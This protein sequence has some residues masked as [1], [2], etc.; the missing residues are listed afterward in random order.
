MKSTKVLLVVLTGLLLTIGS[1][2]KNP[3]QPLPEYELFINEFLADNRACCPD[4][5]G[6]YDAWVEIYNAGPDA[7]DLA[8]MYLTDD[9]YA[10]GAAEW[11]QIP[12]S[13]EALTTIETDSFLVFWFDDQPEQGVLHV[14]Q[15][16]AND[17][18]EIYLIGA[19]AATI[20]DSLLYG[21]QTADISFGRVADSSSTW[22]F[23]TGPTPGES[24]ENGL[25]ATTQML[26]FSGPYC[27]WF[28]FTVDT[29]VQTF[30]DIFCSVP[31]ACIM[32][33]NQTY[34]FEM[35]V[36]MTTL[37]IPGRAYRFCPYSADPVTVAVTGAAFTEEI[38]VPM[39]M[40]WSAAET[41]N[42]FSD[43]IPMASITYPGGTWIYVLLYD[44]FGVQ[45]FQPPLI[46]S[47][48]AGTV[49]TDAPEL[50]LLPPDSVTVTISAEPAD[51]HDEVTVKKSN[52]AVIQAIEKLLAAGQEVTPAMMRA[53]IDAE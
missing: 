41:G 29:G 33:F 30:E 48:W 15:T 49:Y 10:D 14:N 21:Q 5:N 52:V 4:E 6:E 9:H 39:Y 19:D 27:Q 42:P 7:V 25:V 44:E 1:C 45:H 51:L 53:I 34:G 18:D 37:P 35:M 17:G 11:Y 46:P 47:G 3:T 13:D 32:E 16:L 8:G 2:H 20:L 36:D 40:A 38:T 43:E 23:F 28:I 24:N 31:N 50:I 12:D 22:G 26:S